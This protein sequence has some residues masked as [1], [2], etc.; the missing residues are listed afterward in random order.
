[1]A[2]P[3][4]TTMAIIP[5][6]LN[7]FIEILL[8]EIILKNC[9][10]CFGFAHPCGHGVFK[11]SLWTGFSCHGKP[12]TLNDELFQKLGLGTAEERSVK[13][14]DG[15]LVPC[16]ITELVDVHHKDRHWPCAAVVIPGAD[17]VLLGAIDAG[18]SRRAW[19][20]GGVYGLLSYRF[21][22]SRRFVFPVLK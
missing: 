4:T 22:S 16:K 11:K 10:P 2:N 3:I 8:E 19:R 18:I 13:A 20:R 17:S 7:D 21:N 12:V 5:K 9:I 1:M 15:R 14:A 6:S